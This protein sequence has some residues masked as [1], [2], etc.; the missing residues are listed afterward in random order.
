MLPACAVR[1]PR[2]RLASAIA[3]LLLLQAPRLLGAEADLVLQLPSDVKV[4]SAVAIAPQMKLESAGVINGWKITFA[5]LL[6]ATAYDIRLICADGR[7][8][9]GVDMSWYSDEPLAGDVKPMDDDD[10]KQIQELFDGIKAFENK[11]K[12]LLI[13][14]NHE[15]A[16]ILAELIRDTAFYSDK[17][18]EIIWRIELWYFK[19]QHGGWEKIAQANKVLR[20][21][22][23]TKKE[24]FEK[25]TATKWIAELGGIKL[26]K[27]EKKIVKV[28]LKDQP[29]QKKPPVEDRKSVV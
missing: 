24:D 15:R 13:S 26:A 4:A 16:T 23:F 25:G 21:E 3:I 12:M 14:G 7:V 9:Q 6:P 8:F 1:F 2:M 20:R 29:A 5:D 10:R 19:N 17:G 18:G 27:D 22:R 11:R 28:S